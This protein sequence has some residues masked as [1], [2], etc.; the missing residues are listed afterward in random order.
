MLTKF[1]MKYFCLRL[2][3]AICLHGYRCFKRID[4][5]CFAVHSVPQLLYV[6]IVQPHATVSTE[7]C[8]FVRH[9]NVREVNYELHPTVQFF[10]S[11]PEM[12]RCVYEF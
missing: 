4:Y 5:V 10:Q 3:C 2:L 11:Y 8:I 6:N 1:Y 9:P 7:S 12:A